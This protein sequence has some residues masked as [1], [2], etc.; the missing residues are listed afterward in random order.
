MVTIHQVEE[1]AETYKYIEE[2]IEKLQCLEPI[3]LKIYQ[4]VLK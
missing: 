4:N 3:F 2:I 1:I